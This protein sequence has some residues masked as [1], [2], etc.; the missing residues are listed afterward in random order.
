VPA[1]VIVDRISSISSYATATAALRS[2]IGVPVERV[3]DAVRDG[4]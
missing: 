1:R 4:R 3:C 2:M